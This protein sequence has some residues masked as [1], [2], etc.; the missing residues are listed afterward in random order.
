MNLFRL[1]YIIMN[2]VTQMSHKILNKRKFIN[3]TV[4]RKQVDVLSYFYFIKYF[5]YKISGIAIFL[6]SDSF[7]IWRLLK[8][9]MFT[10]FSINSLQK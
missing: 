6:V 7:V 1:I 2:L 8:K 5:I 4:N 10:M 3:I 9:N